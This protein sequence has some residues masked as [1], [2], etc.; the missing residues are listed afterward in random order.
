LEKIANFFK[1]VRRFFPTCCACKEDIAE[2]QIDYRCS[3]VFNA[4]MLP[5]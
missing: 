5:A 2:V 3:D 1:M 4:A